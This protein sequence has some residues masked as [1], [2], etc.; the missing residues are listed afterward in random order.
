[1]APVNRDDVGRTAH[2]NR[3]DMNT[4]SCANA[5]GRPL[6]TAGSKLQW[7]A[8]LLLASVALAAQAAA[9]TVG[10]DIAIT[11]E[12]RY[13]MALEAQAAREYRSMMSLLRQS[14]E[15]GNMQAQEMLGVALLVGPTL[16]GAAVKADRCEAGAWLRRA[17]AQ[18][19]EA[20]KYPL[21]FLNRLRQAPTGKDVCWTSGG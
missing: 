7:C 16:Y 5:T 14:A 12:Q 3:G 10:V 21:D 6:H 4:I 19:S 15:A 2:P 1:M 20:G 11:P 13:Q 8:C 17:V 9:G 18:G